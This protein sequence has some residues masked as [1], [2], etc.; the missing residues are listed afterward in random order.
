LGGFEL[1]VAPQV[2]GQVHADPPIQHFLQFVGK[3]QVLDHERMERH[4]KRGQRRFQ[5]RRHFLCQ[6]RLVSRHIQE[7]HLR[8]SHHLGQSRHDGV[9]KPYARRRTAPNSFSRMVIGVAVP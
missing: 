9:A 6:F 2:A 1:C 5:L 7:R 8:G 4:S 3:R